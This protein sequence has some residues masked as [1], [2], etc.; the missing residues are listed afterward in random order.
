MNKFLS[1]GDSG[2]GSGGNTESVAVDDG[3]VDI[4]GKTLGAANL[5]P[6]LPLSVNTDR[7]LYSTTSLKVSDIE[8]DDHYSI[9][10]ELQKIYNIQSATEASPYI[11][12]FQGEIHVSKIKSASHNTGLEFEN[13]GNL[14]IQTESELHITA[15][16]NGIKIRDTIG[17]VDL[18]GNNIETTSTAETIINAGSDLRLIAGTEIENFAPK[19]SFRPTIEGPTSKRIDINGANNQIDF[20][21]GATKK[22]GVNVG[23]GG[24]GSDLILTADTLSV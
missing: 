19:V 13:N 11:T 2:S 3:T 10:D 18:V 15:A 12:D 21:E 4:Y 20:Y 17:E 9:N 1:G 5:I 23:S 16:G 14:N 22:V 6:D 7:Q 24:A 8:T